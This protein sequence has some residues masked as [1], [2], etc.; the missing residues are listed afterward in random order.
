MRRLLLASTAILLLAAPVAGRADEIGDAITEA[1]RAWQSGDAVAARMA[2][3]EALQLLAQ[4]L[5]AKLAEALPA[6]LPGWTAEE[7]ESS[8]AAG[9]LFGGATQASRSYTNAQDQTVRIQVTTDSPMILQLAAVYANP[10]MA[11][12]MGKLLRIGSQRAIQTS[13]GEIQMLVDNRILVVVDGDAPQ[14][15]KLAYARAI[16]LAQLAGKR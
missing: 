4:R 14:E 9:G 5:A 10:V 2:I 1:S 3:E 7:A 12:S 16:D 8:A 13:D 15:A 6:P 11:G